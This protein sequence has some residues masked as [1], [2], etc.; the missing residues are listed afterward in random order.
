MLCAY[1]LWMLSM[2]WFSFVMICWN[3]PCLCSWNAI[4]SSFSQSNSL[5]FWSV[6]I[7]FWYAMFCYAI[8][9]CSWNA[10]FIGNV[11]L[12]WLPVHAQS[13]LL[14]ECYRVMNLSF[15]LIF[16]NASCLWTRSDLCSWYAMISWI[17]LQPHSRLLWSNGMLHAYALLMLHCCAPGMLS[18]FRFSCSDLMECFRLMILECY[19]VMNHPCVLLYW[20]ASCLCS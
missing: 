13:L 3:A 5:M 12:S 8:C 2:S 1:D 20:N 10:L 16:W 17:S 9:I 6:G 4:M 15:V 18:A 14:L 7:L 11:I 19:R